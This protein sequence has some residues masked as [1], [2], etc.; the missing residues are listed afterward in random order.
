VGEHRTNH[1]GEM[2]NVSSCLDT[3]RRCRVL[4]GSLR[5]RETISPR[6]RRPYLIS[7]AAYLRLMDRRSGSLPF[8]RVREALAVATVELYASSFARTK[9]ESECRERSNAAGTVAC[10]CYILLRLLGRM[11]STS[12]LGHLREI[13]RTSFRGHASVKVQDGRAVRLAP[14]RVGLKYRFH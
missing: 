11:I 12:Q 4:G 1:E 8:R 6:K 3:S 2:L 7:G 5:Y 9:N 14:R 13:A 10:R